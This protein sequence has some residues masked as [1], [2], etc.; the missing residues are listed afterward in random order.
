MDQTRRIVHFLHVQRN[1]FDV[2]IN[3]VFLF[4]ELYFFN[5]AELIAEKLNLD[6]AVTGGRIAKMVQMN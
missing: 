6:G 1:N 2:P 5:M 4:G 3:S